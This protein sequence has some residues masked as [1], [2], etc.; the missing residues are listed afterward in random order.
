MFFVF[1]WNKPKITS[2]GAVQK[3][4]CSNCNNTEYWQLNKIARYFTL[5]FIPIFPHDNDYWYF[6]P[7]CNYGIALEHK[8]F[9]LYKS[10]AEINT[11]F[12]ENKIDQEERERQLNLIY[13]LIEENSKIQESKLLEESKNYAEKVASK[14]D[15]ELL[16][17]FNIDRVKYNKSFIIAVEEE[18]KKRNLI[19]TD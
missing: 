11:S 16:H 17:I 6:C 13:N 18:M 14:T 2:Y 5:F 19:S 15:S 7:I 1:G 4:H 12:L 10:I 9:E 8:N 3:H